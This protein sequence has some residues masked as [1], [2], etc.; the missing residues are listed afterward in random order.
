MKENFSSMTNGS[1]DAGPSDHS[2]EDQHTMTEPTSVGSPKSAPDEQQ[3]TKEPTEIGSAEP[4]HE[5][6]QGMEGP[7]SVTP[8]APVE[9]EEQFIRN[10][11]AMWQSYNRQGLEVRWI[12]G[13]RLN[14]RLGPQDER[15]P[16]G[17]QTIKKVS[18]EVDISESDICRMR[19][20]A[21]LFESME[22]F[23]RKHP[24]A[25]CWTKV[26]AFIPKLL[27]YE[28]TG[29]EWADKLSQNEEQSSDDDTKERPPCSAARS[30]FDRKKNETAF[31]TMLKPVRA[32]TRE[33]RKTE[34]DL[35]EKMEDELVK[36]VK[37]FVAA[38]NKRLK[39][40]KIALQEDV[41]EPTS[42]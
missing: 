1:A 9:D 8:P 37:Q 30:S 11:A 2:Q 32:T 41:L 7:I 39:T 28:R 10:L 27:A 16:H 13:K 34:V 40:R 42:R 17:E 24:N 31:R 38:A 21:S 18:K 35:D 5:E 25:N 6:Q 20:F 22:E 12:T 4:V 33:V 23:H 19:S 15:Q 3:A 14:E 26:K 29:K 36:A